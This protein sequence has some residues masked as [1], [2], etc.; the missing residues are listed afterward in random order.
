MRVFL[1]PCRQRAAGQCSSNLSADIFHSLLKST[2]RRNL[3]AAPHGGNTKS[4][5][6][7]SD[8]ANRDGWPSFVTMPHYRRWTF[9]LVVPW[10]PGGSRWEV[11][12][13]LVRTSQCLCQRAGPIHRKLECIGNYYACLKCS[14]SLFNDSQYRCLGLFK[15]LR[16]FLRPCVP[17]YESISDEG[18][19]R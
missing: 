4:Q 2:L 7:P 18:Q 10:L 9:F 13:M 19:P 1:G 16:S 14:P 17:T 5:I 11:S 8:G 6:R 12:L 3:D 15:E